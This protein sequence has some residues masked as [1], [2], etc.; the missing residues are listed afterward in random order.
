VSAEGRF[1]ASSILPVCRSLSI[2][3]VSLPFSGWTPSVAK[4]TPSLSRSFSK[5]A[6]SCCLFVFMSARRLGL[7]GL[8]RIGLFAV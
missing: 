3:R 7:V 1:L 2:Q 6:V 8:L 5:K 4:T